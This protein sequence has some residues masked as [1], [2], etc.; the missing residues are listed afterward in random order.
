LEGRGNEQEAVLVVEPSNARVLRQRLLDGGPRSRTQQIR[1][2]VDVFA[3]CQAPYST[4]REA[5]TRAR[6]TWLIPSTRGAY[7][8][9]AA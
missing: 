5:V 8:G 6:D 9:V 2:D 4:R 7:S 1:D 3:L